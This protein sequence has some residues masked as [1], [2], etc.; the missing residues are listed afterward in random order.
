MKI[1]RGYVIIAIRMTKLFLSRKKHCVSQNCN[2]MA[3][4]RYA[5]NLR[6]LFRLIGFLIKAFFPS[7]VRFVSYFFVSW[8]NFGNDGLH[9]KISDAI[10]TSKTWRQKK[11][12][13]TCLDIWNN[14]WKK[15]QRKNLQIRLSISIYIV[16][17]FFLQAMIIIII[18]IATHSLR[19]WE[20]NW[21]GLFN[22][23]QKLFTYLFMHENGENRTTSM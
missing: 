18:V 22:Y 8:F 15:N 5:S 11:N 1:A 16:V 17:F 13:I 20:E 19:K 23:K 7:S 14:G 12:A 3:Q 10:R 2:E 6:F 4:F 21:N 9:D